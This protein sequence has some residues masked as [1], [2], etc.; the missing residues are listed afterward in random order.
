MPPGTDRPVRTV[1]VREPDEQHGAVSTDDRLVQVTAAGRIRVVHAGNG[2]V[3]P[4]TTIPAPGPADTHVAY[5]GLLYSSERT[6]GVTS[7][8]R[9]RVTDL[10]SLESWVVLNLPAGHDVSSM[11]P[12]GYQRLCVMDM[13]PAYPQ[14]TMRA[15]DVAERRTVWQLK[16]YDGGYGGSMGDYTLIGTIGQQPAAT[17]YDSAGR[18]VYVNRTDAVDWLGTDALLVQPLGGPGVVQR[19]RL[20]DGRATALGRLPAPAA[21]PAGDRVPPCLNNGERLVCPSS[22]DVRIWSLT[23]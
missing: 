18:Q 7:P 12:C 17:L 1:A 8:W 6:S 20:T 4:K 21:H 13:G 10:S 15:V 5:D 2:Q 16:D 11:W 9:V 14:A 19:V 3:V 22:V 23:G